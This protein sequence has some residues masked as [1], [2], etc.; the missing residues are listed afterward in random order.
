MA[1]RRTLAP[2]R[3]L[4]PNARPFDVL[5]NRMMPVTRATLP[6]VGHAPRLPTR[7]PGRIHMRMVAPAYYTADM[8]RA[9]PDDGNRYEVVNGELLVSPS[10]TLTHQELAGRLYR[11]LV[12]YLETEP[13]GHALFSPADISWGP[14]TL[15]QPDVFVA[16]LD[17][18]RTGDWS[19]IRTLLLVIEILSPS[20]ARYDR[21]TKR[22]LYLAQGVPAY[23]IVNGGDRNVEVWSPDAVFPRVET[24]QL[25]WHPAGAT[26][27][28]TIPL[29]DLFR[30]I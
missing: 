5:R 25:V 15:V 19:R 23:W 27:P 13:I 17:L 20:T 10:P 4:S 29:A 12:D 28:L 21:F 6:I 2:D 16:P 22:R 14:D 18:V 11:A 26:Q 3:V 1:G 7:P 30:P 24:E 9:L 8:V